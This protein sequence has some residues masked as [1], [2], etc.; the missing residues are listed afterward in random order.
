M[1]RIIQEMKNKTF[2]KSFDRRDKSPIFRKTTTAP[3]LDLNNLIFGEDSLKSNN[4]IQ[5]VLKGQ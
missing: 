2:D 4:N 1:G 3:S 5:T